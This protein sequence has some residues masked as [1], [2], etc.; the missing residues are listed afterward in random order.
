VSHWQIARRYAGLPPAPFEDPGMFAL[1]DPA[2][3]RST[4]Q[5]AGFREKAVEIVG[6]TRRFP[7][8]AAAMEHRRNSLPEMRPFLEQ[9]SEAK[10]AVVWKEIETVMRRFERSDGVIVPIE[11]LVAAGTK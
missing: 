8:L 1:G 5:R 7:S 11:R 3:L 2:V 6:S 4:F 10:R 9:M